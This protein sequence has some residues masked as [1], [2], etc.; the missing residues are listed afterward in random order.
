[1]G[2]MRNQVFQSLL[3]I[4]LVCSSFLF[5]F[6]NNF[7]KKNIQAKRKARYIRGSFHLLNRDIS[8]NL[9]ENMPVEDEILSI[10][11]GGVDQLLDSSEEVTVNRVNLREL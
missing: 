4:H 1:M 5:H 9:K 3:P 2:L 11:A 10:P 8:L 6:Q 7:S